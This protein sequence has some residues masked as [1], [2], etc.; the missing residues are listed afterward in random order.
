MASN[1]RQFVAEVRKFN[2][3]VPELVRK[4]TQLIALEALRRV[5]LKTPVDTGR[6]RGNWQVS[7]G[8][9]ARGVL[10]VEDPGGGVAISRGQAAIAAIPPF[11]NV[12]I[13]NNVEYILVLEEG[14]FPDP[15]KGGSG[16]TA[17]GFS[18]QAPNGMVAVTLAE[19]EAF[20]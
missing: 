6:A 1:L 14:G 4:R 12:Y 17:G 7:T 20:F 3:D 19:L 15:P 8:T 16:K 9:P 13:A 2:G 10:A 11:A 18:I 5:V